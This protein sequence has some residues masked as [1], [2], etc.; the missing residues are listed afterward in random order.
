MGTRNMGCGASSAQ[1]NEDTS[2]KAGV[3]TVDSILADD[4]ND[5]PKVDGR[6]K[7]LEKLPECFKKEA[8]RELTDAEIE[9]AKK[10][11]GVTAS[12]AAEGRPPKLIVTI[13]AA[14]AGKSCKMKECFE[15]F[16]AEEGNVVISDGDEVRNQHKGI[17]TALN[18]TKKTLLAGLEGTELLEYTKMCEGIADDQP[19]GFKDCEEW[20]YGNSA[21][22]KKAF[23]KEGR[24]AKKDCLLALT[25]LKESYVKCVESAVADGYQVYA[26]GFVVKPKTLLTRQIGRAQSSGRM[27]TVDAK[28]APDGDLAKNTV[29]KQGKAIKGILDIFAIAEKTGGYAIMYDNSPDFKAPGYAPLAPIY[30]RKASEPPTGD[31]QG[32][33]TDITLENVRKYCDEKIQPE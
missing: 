31:L 10:T 4:P 19:I 17:Q 21:A 22:I 7:W 12:V 11:C 2:A 15:K 14:G 23:F 33:S 9:E 32:F 6:R 24:E 29:A 28:A 13:G 16:Q 5:P 1:T 18:L 3:T 30:E 8:A 20:V 25:A 26:A 27:I